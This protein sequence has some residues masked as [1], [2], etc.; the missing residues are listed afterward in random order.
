[1]EEAE[2]KKQADEEAASLAVLE[3]VKQMEEEEKVG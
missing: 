1:M 2:A 3:L